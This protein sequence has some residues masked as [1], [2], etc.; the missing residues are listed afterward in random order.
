MT[1]LASQIRHS[2][3]NT[4]LGNPPNVHAKV[5]KRRDLIKCVTVINQMETGSVYIVME[6]NRQYINFIQ[7]QPVRRDSLPG[8][9]I[10]AHHRK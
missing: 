6:C 1:R 10:I 2:P 5:K 9:A 3:I 8:R 7:I 4:L